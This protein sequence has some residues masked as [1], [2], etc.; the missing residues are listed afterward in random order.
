VSHREI[1]TERN[2]PYTLRMAKLMA[3][4]LRMKIVMEFNAREMSPKE[5]YEE[6][7]GGYIEGLARL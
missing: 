5:F 4:E 1:G 2:V 6:Y 7:G 3:D